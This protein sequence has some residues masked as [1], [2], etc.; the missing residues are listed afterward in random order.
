MTRSI[1]KAKR[2][3]VGLAIL[4]LGLLLV[5][6]FGQTTNTSRLTVRVTGARNAKGQIRIALFQDATGFPENAS[7]SIRLQQAAIDSQTLSAEAVFDDIPSGTYAV[8]VF[9][10]ENMNGK[11]D[12][13]LG[14]PK[15]GYGASNNPQKGCSIHSYLPHES[16]ITRSSMKCIKPPTFDEAKFSV[17]ELEQ[18]VEIQL[19]Y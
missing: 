11:L 2:I 15:E 10:D 7:Q 6:L 19:I 13:I 4:G 14:A 18:L 8:Y 1:F 17:D 16:S 12:K 3:E 5:P 9:H